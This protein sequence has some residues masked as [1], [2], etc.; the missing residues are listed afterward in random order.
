MKIWLW[1]FIDSTWLLIIKILLCFVLFQNYIRGL[2]CLVGWVLFWN[3]RSKY[4]TLLIFSWAWR[5]LYPMIVSYVGSMLKKK[6]DI[7]IYQIEWPP[8]YLNQLGKQQGKLPVN[9]KKSSL[10]YFYM[11]FD[12]PW[13]DGY[14]HFTADIVSF[15]L[16]EYCNHSPFLLSLANE[17]T[18]FR[19]SRFN[20]TVTSIVNLLFK[21]TKSYAQNSMLFLSW[22]LLCFQAHKNHKI[23]PKEFLFDSKE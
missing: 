21:H 5:K 15:L 23:K 13:N 9:G 10:I 3:N 18:A 8:G 16:L 14:F 6:K 4:I 20:I 19:K 12:C 2:F 22:I 17:T 7:L 1:T 11:S